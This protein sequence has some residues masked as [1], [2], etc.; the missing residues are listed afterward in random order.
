[1]IAA[2]TGRLKDV[3]LPGMHAARIACLIAPGEEVGDLASFGVET[4]VGDIRD[5]GAVSRFVA[6]GEGGLLIHL[7]GIIHPARVRDFEAINAEGTLGL[8]AAARIANLARMVV[9]SSNS[10]IGCNPSPTHRFTEESPYNPYM[11]YG[12]SKWQMEVGLCEMIGKPRTPEITIIRSPWFYG[13]GQPTRQTQFFTMIKDGR[14]PIIGDGSNRRSMG[15]VDNLAQGI[16]LAATHPSAAG[17]IFWMADEIPYSMNQ[18][19]ETVGRVMR[20][21]FGLCVKPNKLRLPWFVGELASLADR[22]LQGAG[23]Y[24]QKIHVLSEMNKTIAC[25]VDKAK[26]LL[27]YR[28]T[29]AL[30]EGM[31]RSIQWCLDNG[32]PI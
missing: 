11:G 1:V 26:R 15:Y 7:A 9:M 21:D 4:V 27:G 17:E 5:A 2:L 31:R 28:P 10:P 16:L 24:Q 23:L 30:E 8:L 25:S 13:P 6:N 14:F 22:V 20:N 18:I 3:A 19:V 29:I 32:Q 12:R